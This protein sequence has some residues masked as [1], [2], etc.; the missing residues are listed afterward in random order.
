MARRWAIR[1]I[2]AGV[3]ILVLMP[4]VSVYHG[5]PGPG[6]INPP[7]MTFVQIWWLT[8]RTGVRQSTV[9]NIVVGVTVAGL[10]SLLTGVAALV[11]SRKRQ[12]ST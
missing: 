10:A 11:I 7:N 12:Q 1:L 8:F 3:V 4:G 9:S 5:D 6:A 2:I